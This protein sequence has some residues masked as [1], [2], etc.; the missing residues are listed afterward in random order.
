LFVPVGFAHGFVTLMDSNMVSYKVSMP[1]DP[2]SEDGI[3]WDDPALE[4]DW[5]VSAGEVIRSAKDGR[6]GPVSSL[7]SPLV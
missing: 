1:Y 3:E 2:T 7:K 5:P 4:I 6:L